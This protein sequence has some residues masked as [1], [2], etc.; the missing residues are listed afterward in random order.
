MQFYVLMRVLMGVGAALAVIASVIMLIEFVEL[1][2]T[3]GGRTELSFVDLLVLTL[4][5]SPSVILQLLP[6]IFLFG[7]MGAFV[8]SNWSQC[9]PRAFRRGVS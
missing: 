2:R 6:F 9:A 7:S 8:T 1:T 3:L 5:K 4:L